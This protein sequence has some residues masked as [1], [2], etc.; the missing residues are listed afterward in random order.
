MDQTV[1]VTIT[2]TNDVPVLTTD[3]AT[4]RERGGAANALA[5]FD[6]VGN[7]LA[8][9]TDED[10]IDTLNVVEITAL[11]GVGSATA[12]APDSTSSVGYIEVEGPTA[13]CASVPTAATAT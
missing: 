13:S 12:V 11:T 1:T 2:G 10:L 8:N 3:D 5:G 9:D 6:G 4:A 7:V